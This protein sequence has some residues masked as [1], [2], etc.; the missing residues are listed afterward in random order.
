M[1]QSTRELLKEAK[2]YKS[3]LIALIDLEEQDNSQFW[4][5]W[6]ALIEV[7][8]KLKSKNILIFGLSINEI[9]KMID[10]C[11]IE[12]KSSHI[13]LKRITFKRA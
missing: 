10:R 8:A 2:T 6:Q 3:C 13:Q 5:A 4:V 11:E 1:T 9:N 12:N 7:E